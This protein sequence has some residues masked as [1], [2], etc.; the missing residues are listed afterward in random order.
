[1]TAEPTAWDA[2]FRQRGKVFL[3]PQEDMAGLLDMVAGYGTRTL[4]DVGCGTGR[5]VV[6]FAQHGFSVSGLDSSPEGIR[7]TEQAVQEAGLSA[8]L[9]L[10][11]VYQ[12]LP[13]ADAFFD[14]VIAVQVIHHARLAKIQHL[15]QEMHRVLKPGGVIFVSVAKLRDQATRFEQIE[16]GTFLPLDGHE[17]GLPH[18][19]FTPDELCDA[20]GQFVGASV[21]LDRTNH[22][23]LRARR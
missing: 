22:Y 15:I 12:R 2:I 6:S 7:L 20:F 14:A 13:Y 16:P 3:R 1:M 21:H 8:T 9:H 17:A 11:D 5:H 10:Q 23:C 19:F 4:L 18:H